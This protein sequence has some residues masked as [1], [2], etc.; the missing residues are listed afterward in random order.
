M[1]NSDGII[2][3][4]PEWSPTRL[5]LVIAMVGAGVLLVVLRL[6]DAISGTWCR[7]SLVALLI[8]AIPFALREALRNA[9]SG[10]DY[11]V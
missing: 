7:W 9:T 10:P 4:G 3:Q 8:L 5:L 6:I 11:R 2:Q 1:R